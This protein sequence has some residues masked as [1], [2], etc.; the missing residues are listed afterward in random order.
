[1]N[2]IFWHDKER[3]MILTHILVQ[4]A[5]RNYGTTNKKGKNDAV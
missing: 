1:M 3:L 5:E 4:N 2:D